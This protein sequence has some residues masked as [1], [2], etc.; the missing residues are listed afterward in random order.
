M[1]ALSRHP[2]FETLRELKGNPR[3]CVLT[4]PMFGFPYCLFNPFFSVYMLALGVT[5]QWIGN[6][7]SIGLVCQIFSTILSGVI[8]DKIG[9]RLTLMICDILAW[10]IPCLIW[11]IAQDVRYFIVAAMLNSL[12]RIAHTAWTCLMVEEAEERH[13]VNMWIWISIFSIS[14]SF[15]TPLGGW[16]VAR[17]GLIPSVRGFFIF[18][19]LMLI[20]KAIVLFTFSHE[21]V[22]GRQRMEET[23]HQSS[24][25]ML[26]EYG[27]VIKQILRSRPI[28][29]ALSLMVIVNIYT[30]ISNNFWGVLFTSK[31]GFSQSAI[32]IYVMLRSVVMA[33]SFFVIGPRINR[34][35]SFRMPLW[36]GFSI[37]IASQGL[38]VFMPPHTIWLM[39]ASVL[40][41]G[42]ALS[43]VNPMTET[44]LAVALE[45]KERARISA[46]VY[47]ALILFT[48]PFGW[49]AGQLSAVNRSL[50]FALNMLLFAVGIG[51][52]WLIDRRNRRTSE[53]VETAVVSER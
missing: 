22:R 48:A 9:R 10:G 25:K 14:T 49:I 15:I 27:G 24:I 39:V 40:L 36:V 44:L 32:S 19:S 28:L 53:P 18:G 23:R 20:S 12:Y 31:L 16:F 41:E 33:I 47:T 13:L 3:V 46:V 50:P 21:T 26:G 17:F 51:L 42:L 1:K 29:A 43:L 11:A 30:T 35:I 37:F 2:L 7:A 34:L 52:V 45:T 38:L 4:E 5:D 8:V 6:I